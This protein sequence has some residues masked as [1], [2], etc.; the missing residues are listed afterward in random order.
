[1]CVGEPDCA[2]CPPL[3]PAFVFPNTLMPRFCPMLKMGNGVVGRADGS[4]LLG[5]RVGEPDQPAWG[6]LIHTKAAYDRVFDAVRKNLERGHE[7]S[8]RII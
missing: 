8:L 4:I 2:H 7:V 5:Q 3:N 1:M 6:S